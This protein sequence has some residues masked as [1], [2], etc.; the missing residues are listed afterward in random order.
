[1]RHPNDCTYP[2]EQLC[3]HNCSNGC[4]KNKMK[5]EQIPNIAR[6]CQQ[7][8]RSNSGMSQW[9]N[10]EVRD[11][12][13]FAKKVVEMELKDRHSLVYY[14]KNLWWTLVILYMGWI[15]L[16]GALLVLIKGN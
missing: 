16:I 5:L 12:D 15:V 2:H 10:M 8:N 9:F 4:L 6:E 1:M 14:D 3:E 11:L 13:R 7:Q